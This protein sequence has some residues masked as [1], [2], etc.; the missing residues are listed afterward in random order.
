[1]SAAATDQP[2]DPGTA[3]DLDDVVD[4]LRALKVWA[5]DPSYDTITRRVNARWSAEGRPAAEQARRGTVVD[6]FRN[7]RRRLNTDLVIAIVRAL[8]D[9]TGY[10][11]HWRQ[12]IRVTLAEVHAGGQVR[13]LDRLPDDS[14]AF[15][16]RKAQLAVLLSSANGVFVLT[17][18]AGVGKTQLA[19]HAGHSMPG[20]DVSLFVNLRGFHPDASQPPAEPGA[21]LD[22]FLRLLDVPA[23]QIPHTLE[24]R[25]AAFA[26]RLSGRRALVVLDNAADEDQVRP[27][28][29]RSRGLLTLVTSRRTLGGLDDVTRLGVDVLSPAEAIRLLSEAVPSV[30]VG[31]DIS[32]YGRVARRCGFLPLALTV[33]AGQMAATTGWTVTD[34][35]DRLDERHRHHRLDSGVELAL[36]LSYQSLPPVRRKLLRRLAGHPGPDLDDQAA[37]ALLDTDLDSTRD[38]L[39]QLAAE[40]LVE[41]PVAGRFS[42]HDLVRLYAAERSVEE[43]RPQDR[44]AALTRLLDHYLFGAA[45]AMDLLYP[46]EKHRR[47]S[48]DVAGRF[49]GPASAKDALVWLDAERATIVAACVHA[50][51]HEW[52]SHAVKLAATLYSYL[53]NGG[54]PAEAVAVHTEARHAARS[55]GDRAAEAGALISLGVVHWQMGDYPAA[56]DEV[57]QSLELF[58]EAGDGRG[59]ARALGNLGVVHTSTGDLELSIDFHE[60][61]L[62]RFIAIGD[63][64]G[65]AN[66]LTNIGDAYVRLGRIDPAA[67]HHSRALEIFRDLGHRGGEATALTNLGDVHVRLGDHRAAIAEHEQALSLFRELGERYGQACTLNGLGE[68]LAG[69]G[70]REAAI[71]TH[72]AALAMAVSIDEPE[73]QARAREALTRLAA[74]DEAG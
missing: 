35:A 53:D 60:Q 57:T 28:L 43:D 48:L 52:P 46:A 68:A 15:T 31:A 22:G 71:E 63:R 4:R 70:R 36:H 26:S 18:M 59:E 62:D 73:E 65:E 12:A 19:V 69:S 66:T 61:A 11:S 30:T 13:V 10:V 44:H 34:H 39:R 24:E 55:M 45:A 17:G 42:L 29:V 37:A 56:I 51:R 23:A 27:L 1:M 8:H 2:P 40:N 7:G 16:G 67:V 74:P 49:A 50:A 33:V 21:V 6:C 9:E 41:Q 38:H 64:V 47:P 54:H 3:R 5:G 58:R 20:C 72:R 14:P 25:A 32:A